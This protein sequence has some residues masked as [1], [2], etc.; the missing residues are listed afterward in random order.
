MLGNGDPASLRAA[1]DVWHQVEQQT[2]S[3]SGRWFCAKYAL[4]S[5]HHRLG[6]D[7]RAAKIIALAELLHPD[8]GGAEMKRRFDELRKACRPSGQ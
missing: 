1:L 7:E 3:G 6:E 4:A 8:F 5:A 2:K